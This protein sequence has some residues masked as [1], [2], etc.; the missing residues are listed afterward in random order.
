MAASPGIEAPYRIQHQRRKTRGHRNKK[1][2]YED[3]RRYTLNPLQF[4]L[5]N[6]LGIT[7]P[8]ALLV[9]ALIYC[10]VTVLGWPQSAGQ[11]LKDQAALVSVGLF[12]IS[13][14]LGSL[15]RLYAA[16][17]VDGA[18]AWLHQRHNAWR[19]CGPMLLLFYL[20]CKVIKRRRQTKSSV[21]TK[22]SVE[23]RLKDI[24][25]KI[26]K[27]TP[28]A[29][30]IYSWHKDIEWVWEHDRFP[31]PVWQFMKFRLYHPGEMFRFFKAYAGCFGTYE[32]RGT[33]FFNY[34][35][36]VIYSASR[37][38]GDGLAEE[39]QAAEGVS[40]FFAGAFNAL[41]CSSLLFLFCGVI[42]LFLQHDESNSRS[43]TI[44]TFMVAAI[45]FLMSWLIV[46]GGRFRRIRLN[47]VDV[48][49]DA[50]YLVHRHPNECGRCTEP[51][52]QTKPNY[53]ERGE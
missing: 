31:Y 42:Q 15:I 11:F 32:R 16:D 51:S 52:F 49:F 19:F 29:D 25:D 17:S 44:A 27:D 36:T 53:V 7:I 20:L 5:K 40:R 38:K 22:L 23:A 46:A 30:D 47:E 18:S 37:Q 43:H 1:P 45:T 35:K 8:G 6:L 2:C 28:S 34:C 26:F 4:G 13:Y 3:R 9:V 10:V 41:A 14:L 50:F 24:F 39:V 33:E 21:A 48:V 12:L